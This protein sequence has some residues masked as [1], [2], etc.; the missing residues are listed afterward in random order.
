MNYS[1]VEHNECNNEIQPILIPIVSSPAIPSIPSWRDGCD[2]TAIL[3]YAAIPDG[4]PWRDGISRDSKPRDSH[5]LL[6]WTWLASNPVILR[7][8]ENPSCYE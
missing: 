5:Y 8:G 7:Q 4:Q 1:E 6:T 3:V 2:G